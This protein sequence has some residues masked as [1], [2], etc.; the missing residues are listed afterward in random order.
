VSRSSASD[1]PCGCFRAIGRCPDGVSLLNEPWRQ[2]Q[3]AMPL[4]IVNRQNPL[5]LAEPKAPR[6]PVAIS[7]QEWFEMNGVG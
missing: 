5:P 2:R 7:A 1:C 6:T 4:R 3:A